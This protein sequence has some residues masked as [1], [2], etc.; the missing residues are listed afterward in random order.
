MRA[1]ITAVLLLTACQT[2]HRIDPAAES[3]VICS[4]LNCAR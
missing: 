1:I 3:T 2:G 4:M